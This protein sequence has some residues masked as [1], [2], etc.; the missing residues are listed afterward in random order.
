[1]FTE[2]ERK[3]P[4]DR[5]L[6][7]RFAQLVSDGLTFSICYRDNEQIFIVSTPV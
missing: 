5:R 3:R 1:M 2:N 7:L 6:R 4:T